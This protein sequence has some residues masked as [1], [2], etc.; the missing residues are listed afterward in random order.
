[1]L[2]TGTGASTAEDVAERARDARSPLA[3]ASQQPAQGAGNPLG[4]TGSPTAE[5]ASERAGSP[6][7]AGHCAKNT[8]E[9][10]DGRPGRPGLSSAAG[11]GQ[12]A[13]GRPDCRADPS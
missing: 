10:V 13:N 5:N 1:A 6:S 7:P 12:A 9:C 3:A 4:P 8:A 2:G 11:A